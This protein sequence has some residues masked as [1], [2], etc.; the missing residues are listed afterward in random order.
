VL[1]STWGK[2]IDRKEHFIR[3]F[4]RVFIKPS[5]TFYCN[6]SVNLFDVDH[7]TYASADLR[8]L[9]ENTKNLTSFFCNFQTIFC[10]FRKSF[11]NKFNF[12]NALKALCENVCII[13]ENV[14]SLFLIHRIFDIMGTFWRYARKKPPADLVVIPESVSNSYSWK[15]FKLSGKIPWRGGACLQQW[16]L[17]HW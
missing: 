15:C 13:S 10:N 14:L 9:V 4:S 8:I 5:S 6:M 16:F 7:H 17:V 12:T 2:R 3:I 1:W 11:T